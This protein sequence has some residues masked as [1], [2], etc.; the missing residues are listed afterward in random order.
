MAGGYGPPLV[1]EGAP[2]QPLPFGLFTV[3]DWRDSTD[4]H[5]ANGVEWEPVTCQP[6]SAIDD[7]DCVK[8]QGFQQKYAAPPGTGSAERFTV[9]GAYRCGT[10]AG[11][12]RLAMGQ[13]KAVA[14]LLG[15]EQGQAEYMAWQR[16]AAQAADITPASGALAPAY[17]LAALED[18]L[19]RNYGSLG[20]LHLDR[21][22]ASLS[23]S[24]GA[25]EAKGARLFT[26]IGTPVSAG[27]GYPKTSPAGAAAAAGETWAFASPAMFGYRGEVYTGSAQNEVSAGGFDYSHN[28]LY[29]VANRD[30][31]VAFDPCGVAAVRMKIA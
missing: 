28:D 2:R 14:H 25:I 6:A 5:W 19:G 8:M 24:N 29:A 17:A 7:P 31:V 9:Q 3:V 13:E 21:G 15:R 16:M 10:P 23:S 4:P 18:W 20:V 22:A 11:G 26:N 30:Y 12:Q 27:G 1:V